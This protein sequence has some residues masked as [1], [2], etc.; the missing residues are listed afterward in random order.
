MNGN[1]INEDLQDSIAII[2][3]SGRFPGANDI[4]EYWENISKG[5]ESISRYTREELESKGVNPELLDN[6]NYV[7]ANGIIEG[8]EEFDSGFFGFTPREADYMDPQQR[9]FLETCYKAIENA[10]YAS[11]NTDNFIGV[12]GGSGPNNYILKNLIKSPAELK[13]LGELQAITNNSKDYLTTYV[14]YKLNFKGPSLDIQTACSTSLVSVHMACLNLLTYQCNMA[15]AGGVFIQVP[16]GKGYMYYPGEIFSKNGYCRPFDRDADGMLFGEGAGVVVL[17]RYEDAVRDNDTIWA[18]IRG[19]AINND[20]SDKVGFLAPSVNGQIDAIS[21]AQAFAGVSPDKI[22]YIETHGTGTKIG[23]PIEI[24]A[25]ANVFKPSTNR[26]NFCALGS[27]KANIGHLDAGAGIAGLIKTVLA[28]KNKKIPPSVN[29]NSPNP[30][31]NLN[32]SPFYINTEL[33]EWETNGTPR[34]AGVS[35]FGVGGTNAHCVVQ[36]APEQT[37][38]HTNKDY[39]LIC[40]SAKTKEAL[41]RQKHELHDFLHSFKG[42]LADVSY[43]LLNGRKNYKYRA[44]LLAHNTK[45]AQDRLLKCATGIQFKTNPEITFL[46]TGQGSQYVGM[47]RDLYNE[48]SLFK[49]IVNDSHA[50]LS[51]FQIDLKNILFENNGNINNTGFA[52]PAIFVIQY[53]IYKLL[54]NFSIK[55]SYL[56]GHSIGEI[57]AACISGLIR[58]E[59][60]LR[61]VSVRGRLMQA[62]K[63][64]SMLSVQLPASEIQKIV[65]DDIDIALLNAPNFCV[66]SGENESIDKFNIFLTKNYPNTGTVKLKTSH[67]FHSRMMDPVLNEFKNELSNI[68]FGNINIPFISNITG[69]WAKKEMVSDINYWAKHIRSTVN[70]EAGIKEVIENKNVIFLEVGPGTSLTTLLTQFDTDSKK[71][72]SIPTIRHPKNKI[73]D[74]LFFLDA[75]SKIWIYGGEHYFFDNYKD[76]VRSRIPLPT[77]PFEKIKHWIEPV[78]AFDFNVKNDIVPKI[79]NGKEHPFEKITTELDLSDNNTLSTNTA[80]NSILQ[81]WIELLG[82]QEISITDNFFD[83]GGHSLIASQVINRIN[84]LFKTDLPLGSLFDFPTV[85]QISKVIEKDNNKNHES[86]SLEKIHEEKNLPVSQDQVR[87]WILHQFDKNPAYNIPFTYILKGN[88]D[89][90]LLHKCLNEVFNRHDILRSR[91]ETV[92]LKPALTLNPKDSFFIKNIDLSNIEKDSLTETINN[93]LKE[94]IRTL[95]DIANDNL[96]RAYLIKI[97]DQESIFHITIHHIVFDGWSWGIFVKEFNQI[98]KLLTDGKTPSLPP[99][100]YQYYE[101]ANWQQKYLQEKNFESSISYWKN[102]LNNHPVK[103]NFP[104]DFERPN[105]QKGYGGREFFKIS[106]ELTNNLKA[107]SKERNVTEFTTYLSAFSVLLNRYSGDNDICIG[108]P[109][110]NRPNSKLEKIIGFFVNTIV[111]RLN[112]DNKLSF[113]DFLNQSKKIV[114][115]ALDHQDLP[116]EKLVEVIQPERQININPIYQVLFAWQNTPRPPIS[117]TNAESVRYSVPEGVSPLDITVYMWEENGVIEGEVEFNIDLLTRKTIK[118]ITDNFI[119]L[120]ENICYAPDSLI[121]DI[122]CISKTE[123][124]DLNRFNNTKFTSSNKSLPDLF[125][126]QASKTPEDI[127]V[128]CGDEH[129]SYKELDILSNKI[130]NFLISKGVKEKDILAISFSRNIPMLA[131]TLAILKCGAAYLPIDP[132]LPTNRIKYML[133]DSSAK[134]LITE[135]KHKHLFDFYEKESIIS[136][137]NTLNNIQTQ[138]DFYSP[139]NITGEDMA[140]LIYTS[141]STGNP[142]G[143]KIPHKAVVNFLESMAIKPGIE[144]KDTLLAVTTQSFDISVLELFLPLLAGA[145]VLVAQDQDTKNGK[146]LI[147]LIEKQNVTI[148]QATPMTWNILLQNNWDGKQNL[149]ALCGGEPIPVSLIESLL[150]KTAELWNMYGPTE[151][152]VWSAC[153]KINSPKTPVLVGNPIHNTSIYILSENN[154]KMPIG[155]IGE[156]AVGGLG[157]ALGYHNNESLTSKQFLLDTNKER[158]YKTGDLGRIKH[159]GELE[160][161]GRRDNQIKLRGLRIELGEIEAKL[162]K[163]PGVIEA[164]VKVHKFAELDERLIAFLN[165]QNTNLIDKEAIIAQL[166]KELPDYMIPSEILT[167]NNFPRTPNGKIDREALTY[168]P[169]ITIMKNNMDHFL[170]GNKPLLEKQLLQIWKRLL[171]KQ[172][173]TIEDNFFDIGGNS[174]TIIQ[175][176]FEINN[177]LKEEIDIVFYF[178]HATIKS[179]CAYYSEFKKNNSVVKTNNDEGHTNKKGLRLLGQRRKK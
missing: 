24:E 125:H 176:S 21:R 54:E 62:Q 100:D 74:T 142:K 14:S 157:V 88:V 171:N 164:V 139:C 106:K 93:F 39:H 117:L 38:Y 79:I 57:T 25:L 174:I 161:F 75:I 115:E 76:E 87:L 44:A 155:A 60:A 153:K 40:L 31:L 77:Y 29:Y 147:E 166:R 144:Q 152:T 4:N 81:I 85:K 69:T 27:V 23:D 159:N 9:V 7:Y 68:E 61:L 91:V 63:Q 120:L 86:I 5:I 65:P 162:C 158:I 154:V 89:F 51:Q 143:V 92:D 56:V 134:F 50:Y 84:D 151:T 109:T 73:S 11:D 46:L 49:K 124:E 20:G 47:A 30:N 33:K 146:K 138:T 26:K 15:L 66:V 43:T 96:Y 116:F 105:R 72:I 170:V 148:M 136:Y 22:S 113:N 177:L 35:A 2:G 127:A 167:I 163:Q 48:F 80:Q 13:N 97:S 16:R 90:D 102:K 133:N 64:G 103:I 101:Y 18:V 123:N 175:L 19:T 41:E 83:L 58:F 53:A 132:N 28:L 42:E 122:N 111:L 168:K 34:V 59:D 114:I 172:D 55:P 119:T 32:D 118:R 107:F 37:S 137:N 135:D 156:V 8:A 160:L 140:Y 110:A 67:A 78:D 52:Q 6:P 71:N 145:I 149:K 108:T 128:I 112:I 36:E 129:I 82:I 141:G 12:F 173:I 169:E 121:S 104:Y 126:L 165:T 130:A 1:N 98:Y 45:S 99:V 3:L 95:F 70:F 94:E 131:N 10:G 17:K 150:P 179:F 178:E